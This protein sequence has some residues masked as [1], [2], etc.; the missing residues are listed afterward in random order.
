MTAQT[1]TKVTTS[2]LCFTACHLLLSLN[3][4]QLE[5]STGRKNGLAFA[6]AL[7]GD[8]HSSDLKRLKAP[9]SQLMN[10]K[11]FRLSPLNVFAKLTHPF[12]VCNWLPSPPSNT[13]PMGEA[14][15]Q[16]L[17]HLEK[18]KYMCKLY[19]LISRITKK[20]LQPMGGGKEGVKICI[21][22]PV[23]YNLFNAQHI[24]RLKRGLQTI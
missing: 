20:S 7:A 12:S 1:H 23:C 14:G 16:Y 5:K 11:I 3:D 6:R 13:V 18:A 24:H 10:T 8:A 22:V 17:S 21:F 15:D 2:I 9:M 19:A 4:L